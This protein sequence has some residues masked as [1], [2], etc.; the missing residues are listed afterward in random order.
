MLPPSV[1]AQASDT[2]DRVASLVRP[3]PSGVTAGRNR[4]HGLSLKDSDNRAERWL[5]TTRL[6]VGAMAVRQFAP[7][8]IDKHS[9]TWWAPVASV[10]LPGSGQALLRQQRSLAYLVA[11]AFLVIQASRVKKDYEGARSRYQGIAA[12]VARLQ[13]GADRPVGPW[14]YYETLADGSITSSGNYD[15]AIS[16]KFTPETDETTYNGRQWLLARTL[17]W[18]SPSEPPATTTAEYQKAL[19]FYQDRAVQGSFRWSWRDNQNAKELY[20]QTIN[21]ANHSKQDRVSMIGLVAANHLLSLVDSYITVRMRRYGG[22]GLLSASIKSEL[23]PT[24]IPGDD[25]FAAALSVSLPIPGSG[26]H[27]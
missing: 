1:A 20:L 18:A 7:S 19:L 26:R 9:A 12:D 22:A 24:G 21:E 17:Y 15:L 6:S 3:R 13:F 10:V 4:A 16:G 25:L 5:D 2:S 14:E 27:P 11:E 8:P 23:R